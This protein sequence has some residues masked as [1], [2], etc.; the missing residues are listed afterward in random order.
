M[1]L[2]L[3][4]PTLGKVCAVFFLSWSSLS[5]ADVK[6]SV[7]YLA[8]G[9]SIAFGDNG[10][11]PYTLESRPDNRAFIGYPEI[12]AAS[13]YPDSFV[14]LGCPG[15]TSSSLLDLNAP[16]RCAEY[17]Q[18]LPLKYNYTGSQIEAAVEIVRQNPE[19]KTITMSIGGNDFFAVQ[20]YCRELNP[21][22]PEAYQLCLQETIGGAIYGLYLN[23][24][25]S[26]QKLREAGFKGR[27]VYLGGYSL[28]YRDELLNQIVIGA[29]AIIQSLA[30]VDNLV[31]VDVFS[32]FGAKTQP[33]GGDTCASGLLIKNP[34]SPLPEGQEPCDVHTSDEGTRTLAELLI[35][36]LK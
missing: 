27:F 21:E 32:V 3:F 2:R 26:V 35:S 12:V 13:L 34:Q 7:Q 4:V 22:N 23:V 9:D 15:E 17:R 11:I 14:N 31:Y 16:S 1:L 6:Q 18:K 29:N 8:L 33:V 36:T 28:D 19:L 25:T 24:Q 30:E 5:P 20:A 10:Y